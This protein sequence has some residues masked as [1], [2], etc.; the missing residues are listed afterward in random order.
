MLYNNYTLN[1]N[2][3][4]GSSGIEMSSK[5]GYHTYEMIPVEPNTAYYIPGG[6]RVALLNRAQTP[7]TSINIWTDSNVGQQCYILTNASAAYAYITI[8]DTK[9]S[10]QEAYIQKASSSVNVVETSVISELE[11]AE[12][13][14]NVKLNPSSYTEDADTNYCVWKNIPVK[15]NT[16][17]KVAGAARNWYL[18][19]DGAT[20]GTF[21]PT[22]DG[23]PE[24]FGFITP[25][26]AAS[27]SI[28][29]YKTNM[30]KSADE[31]E[32]I[33]L[34]TVYTPME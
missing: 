16:N 15:P 24:K 6:I 26:T 2:K 10:I 32:L 4:L 1:E 14:D 28:S 29:I 21:N 17:Y 3:T 27:V 9:I 5:S 33:E 23:V 12:F 11:G 7:T 22:K 18:K 8:L 19:E 30:D 31:L 34:A 13:V 25:E 20:C